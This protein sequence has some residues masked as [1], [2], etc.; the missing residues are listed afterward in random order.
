MKE[1]VAR[2]AEEVEETSQTAREKKEN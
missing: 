2:N 1:V